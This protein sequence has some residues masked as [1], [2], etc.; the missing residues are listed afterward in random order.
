MIPWY[1]RFPR[2]PSDINSKV[3]K[4]PTPR[5]TQP[6]WLPFHH[7]LHGNEIPDSDLQ[8]DLQKGAIKR[9][10]NNSMQCG[11]ANANALQNKVTNQWVLETQYHK[12][13]K[14]HCPDSFWTPCWEVEMQSSMII[15][16]IHKRRNPPAI[17]KGTFR[18][19]VWNLRDWADAV[20]EG[21]SSYFSGLFLKFPENPCKSSEF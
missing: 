12:K 13:L 9:S 17:P 18:Q 19:L 14:N 5:L 4:I 16:S 11:N 21:P 15:T 1:K 2:F 3:P 8:K 10:L 6:H 20:A 7:F